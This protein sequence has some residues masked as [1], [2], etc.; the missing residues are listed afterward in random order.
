[1][2][3][4]AQAPPENIR[5]LTIGDTLPA[6]LIIHKVTNYPVSSIRLSDLKGKITILDFW[7]TWCMSCISAMPHMEALQSTY[8]DDLTILLTNATLSDNDKKI[9]SFIKRQSRFGHPVHLPILHQDTVL[10]K[11]F[12][13]TMLP[14]YVWLGKNLE[15]L[16]ITDKEGITD[17]NIKAVIAGQ[18][19][20]LQTKNDAL[21]FDTKTPLLINNNGGS[22]GEFV[23]RS[24]LTNYKQGLGV[25]AGK[26]T[27]TTGDTKRVYFINY[28]L[29]AI[30][31]SAFADEF[32]R[33]F[34]GILVEEYQRDQATITPLKEKFCY[35]L[36]VPPLPYREMKEFIR[37]DIWRN[38]RITVKVEK[39]PIVFYELRTVN[40]S[41]I[42]FSKGG[43]AMY[44]V[45][46]NEQ[47]K[48]FVNQSTDALVSLI[49]AITDLP[50]LNE[51]MINRNMDMKLPADIYQYN[52][53]RLKRFLSAY[54]FALVRC[55]E[56]RDV[57]IVT[58]KK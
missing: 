32:D 47:N 15:V 45:D 58:D 12:P 21:L 22:P 43:E 40:T 55:E 56:G 28:S 48:L 20:Q 6:D 14:H 26:E 27:T 51:S 9:Q 34:R 52:T 1:M 39:R 37:Q 38:F 4:H 53:D 3:S 7:A 13:H 50:V 57:A 41:K 46:R 44:I 42:P 11:Y 54:G 17:V 36:I 19:I 16:A 23:Y 10:S 18:P 24:I 30:L 8:K 5:P 29:K 2:K 31:Q 25:L 49:M 33:G 35:E